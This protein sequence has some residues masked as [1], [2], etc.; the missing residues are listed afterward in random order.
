MQ[1]LPIGEGHQLKRGVSFGAPEAMPTSHRLCDN[2]VVR[3]ILPTQSP[4]NL[5][6]C[7]HRP[8]SEP[9]KLKTLPLGEGFLQKGPHLADVVGLGVDELLGEGVHP[10]VF[11]FAVMLAPQAFDQAPGIALNHHFGNL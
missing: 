11:A 4:L 2:R 7:G 6:R 8:H 9:L 3:L 5:G 10:V 1:S